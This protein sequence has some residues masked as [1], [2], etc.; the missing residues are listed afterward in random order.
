I[1]S[2]YLVSKSTFENH[3]TNRRYLDMPSDGINSLSDADLL[4]VAQQ[5]V[6]AMTPDPTVYAATAVITAFTTK[7]STFGTA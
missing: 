1:F 3:S 4:I 5:V 6:T 2:I 7:K